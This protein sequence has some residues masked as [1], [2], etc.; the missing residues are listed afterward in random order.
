AL[1]TFSHMHTIAQQLEEP[2]F[3]TL[4]LMNIGVELE[5]AGEKQKAVEYLEKARDLSFHT[6]KKVAAMVHSYLARGYAS[7]CDALRFQRAIESAQTLMSHS[8][9]DKDNDSDQV[10]YSMSSILAELSN[11]YPEIRKPR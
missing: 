4:A 7:S 6:S 3:Q 11:G 9:P 1:E 5:R 2:Y 8:K 10:H